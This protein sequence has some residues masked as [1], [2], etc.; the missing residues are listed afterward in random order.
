MA[1]FELYYPLEQ[2]LEGTVFE[3]DPDDSGGC[4]KI[5]LTM[6]DL[7]EYR[8][9]VDQDGDVDV[10]DMKKMTMEQG[11]LVLKKLYWDF[12]QADKITNQK[13][14]EFIVDSGLNQGRILIAKYLQSTLGVEVDGHIGSKTLSSLNLLSPTQIYLN[15]YSLRLKRYADIVQARPSQKKFYKGWMNRLNAI[16]AV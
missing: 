15:L 12:F 4:T 8:L 9:D 10:D 13:L 7:H 11:G 5:G 1:K 6:D 14:A 2:K 3:N 16:K